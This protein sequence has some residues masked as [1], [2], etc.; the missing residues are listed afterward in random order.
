MN[1][2]KA[3]PSFKNKFVYLNNI[4][5]S[6]IKIINKAPSDTKI[7]ALTASRL[8]QNK[9]IDLAIK[10]MNEISHLD[11]SLDIYGEGGKQSI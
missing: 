8:V 6:D 11:I 1:I 7:K 5:N 3:F 10:A 2:C 9:G 4:I